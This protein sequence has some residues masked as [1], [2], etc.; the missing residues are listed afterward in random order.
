MTMVNTNTTNVLFENLS[1]EE[2]AIVSGGRASLALASAEA[3][4]SNDVGGAVFTNTYTNA[5]DHG[6]HTGDS[7]SQS[8]SLAF[9]DKLG[10][11][12]ASGFA[13]VDALFG[14][15]GAATK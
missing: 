2:T 8:G 6:T 11:G 1:E 13:S 3:H 7:I 5:T 10:N 12:A 4:Y 9:N 14:I 15:Q